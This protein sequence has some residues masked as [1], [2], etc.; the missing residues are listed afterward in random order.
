MLVPDEIKI[1]YKKSKERIAVTI[2]SGKVETTHH[3]SINNTIKWCSYLEKKLK[4]TDKNESIR[5]LADYEL[6]YPDAKNTYK[7]IS[8]LLDTVLTNGLIDFNSVH[9]K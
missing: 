4:S 7:Y 9:E 1:E 6:P 3:I 2:L 5:F 8:N